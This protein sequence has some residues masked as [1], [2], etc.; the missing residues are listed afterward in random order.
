MSN[1]VLS[2]FHTATCLI[3]MTSLWGSITF[4]YD[5][6]SGNWDPRERKWFDRGYSQQET[7]PW[8]ESRGSC[9]IVRGLKFFCAQ[10]LP[11]HV[12]ATGVA[13]LHNSDHG[14]LEILQ[15]PCWLQDDIVAFPGHPPSL[16]N[17]LSL[18]RPRAFPELFFWLCTVPLSD[19]LRVF[20]SGWWR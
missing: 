20:G 2:T 3:I 5:F 8:L 19:V 18:G 1:L 6:R 12:R 9:P 4:L 10:M 13:L 15:S 17:T 11:S 16:L 14:F 7:K